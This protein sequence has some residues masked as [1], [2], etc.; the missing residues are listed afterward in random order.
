[1]VALKR[2][3]CPVDL[4]ELSIGALACAGSIADRYRGDLS[5]LHV[6]PSFEPMEVPAGALFG[7]V[8][9]VY[10]LPPDEIEAQLRD[11]MRIAGVARDRARVAARAGEPGHVIVDEARAIE[12]D[13]IVMGTHGRTGWDR[14]MLGS[15]AETVLRSAPCSVMTVPAAAVGA[16]GATISAVLCPVD[17]A[18]DGLEA[19]AFAVD[20]ANRADASVRFLHVVEWLRDAEVEGYRMI[21][22][23]EQLSALIAQLPQ[24][25]KGVTTTVTAGIAHR[26]ISEVAL[27]INADVIVLGAR[28]RSGTSDAALGHTAEHV[29]RA[30]TGPVLTVRPS[31]RHTSEE[32]AHVP[33]L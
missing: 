7:P 10:P 21:R 22:E 28:G 33:R 24:V 15:V 13:L 25:E 11:A 32:A 3:L 4:S 29:V 12:A 27:D 19:A 1:M 16:A 2:V 6:V 26:R 23:R 8:K 30:G 5:V 31:R 17:F 18:P 14:L 20:L 9:F